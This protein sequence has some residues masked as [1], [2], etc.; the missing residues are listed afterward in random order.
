MATENVFMVPSVIMVHGRPRDCPRD[1]FPAFSL[2]T[3]LR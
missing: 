2:K 1:F 3:K